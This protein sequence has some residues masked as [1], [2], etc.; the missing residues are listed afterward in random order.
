MA[1]FVLIF[2]IDPGLTDLT[3]DGSPNRKNP[4]TDKWPVSMARMILDPG[5]PGIWQFESL[6][7]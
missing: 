4:D 6:P 5:Y 3:G 7:D 1:G 2:L